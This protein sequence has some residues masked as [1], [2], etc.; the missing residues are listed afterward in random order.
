MTSGALPDDGAPGKQHRRL[1]GRSTPSPRDGRHRA[2][3][4]ER[5]PV[6][7]PPAAAGRTLSVRTP[8]FWMV[9]VL[10]GL[11]AWRIGL[12]FADAARLYPQASV[13]AFILFAL[14]AVPFILL[15]REVDYL[16]REPFVLLATAFAWGGVVATAM[17]NVGNT[18]AV[19]ILAKEFSPDFA[20]RWGPAL[21]GPTIEETL[22]ALGVVA[23]VL[24]AR[25]HVNSVVDGFVYGGLVGLGFQ[26]VEDFIYSIN[27]VVLAG[28]GDSIPPVVATFLVR[29]FLGG[30]WSHTLFTALVGAGVGYAVVREERPLR[31]R[32]GVAVLAYLG[33][34]T[35]HFVWNSPLLG[36]GFGIGVAGLIGALLLK[37]IPG[38]VAVLL[39]LHVARRHEA[40]YYLGRLN[41][42]EPV[43]V[44]PEE[45]DALVTA[46]GRT[47][48]RKQAAAQA[49]L[50]A[51]R[52][53]RKL[54]R[55]QS[56]LAVEISRCGE[57]SYYEAVRNPNPR[58]AALER[59]VRDI[60]SAR[61]KLVSLG[62][63]VAA[64]YGREQ[65]TPLG[66][67]SVVLAVL[68]LV[69]P[70][71]SVVA[72]ALAGLGTLHARRQRLS[73]D[74]RLGIAGSVGVL[75]T[76]LWIVVYLLHGFNGG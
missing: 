60:L 27:A 54:Q 44:A 36:D 1:G 30:L 72:L 10:L 13:T 6:A 20:A 56:R 52:A 34:W 46:R 63:P 9:L 64:R 74:N 57:S 65:H 39:L 24:L 33:A 8:A 76:A 18:A 75:A 67:W 23:I 16:E 25:R 66:M 73:P 35:L 41:G 19:E 50:R 48:A 37:G 38:F 47:A 59:C 17:A 53:V 32:V 14:Y 42:I 2:A 28:D 21:V 12:I 45:M 58:S 49:G 26:V 70:G 7:P 11:G 43:L 71:L 22:K 15:V 31:V 68:G 55:A 4:A 5:P 61:A 29:G 62:V 51:D 69:V 40:G 3:Y